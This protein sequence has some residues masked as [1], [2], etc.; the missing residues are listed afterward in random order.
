MYVRRRGPTLRQY[1][2]LAGLI[3]AVLVAALIAF[4]AR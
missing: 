3:L 4:G 1:L 2:M